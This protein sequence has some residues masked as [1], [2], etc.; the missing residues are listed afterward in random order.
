MTERQDQFE[1]RD[2]EP[3]PCPCCG[4]EPV[5]SGKRFIKWACGRTY[6]HETR[7]MSACTGLD[8]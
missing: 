7:V 2:Y 8:R 6:H 5:I 3:F 1:P 4:A